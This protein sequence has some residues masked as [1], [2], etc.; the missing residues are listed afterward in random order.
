M[1]DCREQRWLFQGLGSRKVEVDFGGGYLSSDGGGLILRELERHSG[2]LRDFAGCFVDSRDSRYIEHSVEEL[3]SQRIHGLVL[4]YEDLNDHDHLRRDPIHGLIAGKSDP[5]G[6]DRILERDKGKALAAQSTLNRLELSAEAVD[7]R[8]HKVQAQP[9]KVQ[10]LLIKRGVKAIP[11]RSAEIVLD[12]DATD[13]P[14]HGRQEGA[15]FNGYYRHYCYLPLYCFCGNIPLLAQLRDCKRDASDGTLEALQK[16]VP[17]IRRRFG[18]KVR[19][20]VRADSGFAREA[21]MAWCEAN[22]VFYCFGLA[23]NERLGEQ[24]ESSFESLK[25][26]IKEGE[27]ESPCRS[28]TEFE[29]STLKSWTRARRVIGKAEILPKGDNPRFI[30][31]NLPKDGWGDPIQAARFEPAALNEKF[32]CARGDMENRIKEQQMDLFADRTSTHWMAS[33]Q[34][35]LWFSAFAHLI[36]STLQA[37]VLKGT[38]LE[39]ASIGQIRLRLFKIAARLT[40]SVRRIHIELCS[41]YPLQALFGLVHQRLAILGAPA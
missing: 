40:A 41:A 36:M 19:I 11:R 33:N 6:Q 14:L 25:A 27:V 2:L 26:Q 31:T 39:V 38:E 34:L 28:F 7:A 29:Y 35:R 23:R 13:D 30:V 10:E 24:L 4:G 37:E 5:L 8:Y 22:E 20:I 15:Y 9:D 32:Y 12:L 17:A 16:I 3:V 21:I 18:S 1:T